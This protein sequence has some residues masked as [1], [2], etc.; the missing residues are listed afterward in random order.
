LV[1]TAKRLSGGLPQPPPPTLRPGE[2]AEEIRLAVHSHFGDKAPVVEIVPVLAARASAAPDKIRLRRSAR[3]SDLDAR[4]LIEHEAFVHVATALNGR[5]QR[6]VPI[7]SANHPGTTRTQEGLAVFAELIS[8]SLDP[9]RFLRLAHRV[10]GVQ[11]ALDGADFIEV[12]EYF[13]EHASN[14]VEAFESAARIFRG[15]L[16]EGGAPFTKDMV[17]LDGLCRVHVFIRAVIDTG[18]VDCL[19]LLFAGKLD[20]VDVPAL[21]ELRRI[22]LCTA[23]KF[24]PPWVLDPRRLV[25]YFAVTDVIG[26]ASTG[27]LRQHYV[28]QL[29][30]IPKPEPVA[31]SE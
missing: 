15:G 28:E 22:G 21:I 20:L 16:V 4:Q 12:Y 18:R 25:A 3:F 13:V 11:M 9:Q 8:G 5:R 14:R 17:Y 29:K 1:R 26:R 30:V 31:A 23:P 24:L 10:I 27:G 2:I 6:H 7:L 19:Q